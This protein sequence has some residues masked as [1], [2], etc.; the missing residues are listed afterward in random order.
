M[1]S[2]PRRTF[3]G[4]LLTTCLVLLA[5]CPLAA[6]SAPAAEPEAKAP[7]TLDFRLRYR[8]ETS[9][10]SGRFH[11]LTR[12]E[13]WRPEQTAVVVCDMWDLHHCLNATRRGAEVAPRMNQV[14]HALRDRGVTVVHAPSNCMDFYKDHPGR[15]AALNT[16]KAAKL[17]Q[18]IGKW[19]YQIPRE[20]QGVYPI[21]QANGGEDDDP[22]E[23]AE[24]AAKLEKMGRNPRRPWVRQAETLDIEDGDFIS[25][26]GEEIWSIF[27]RRGVENVILVGVHTNMCVLGRPFGLRQMAQNGKNVV[28]MRDMT[29]TMYDP[30]QSPRVSHFTGTDLIVE[31]IEKYV[32]PTVTSDQVLGGET[33][34]F[35][36][37]TRPRLVIVMAEQEYETN[38]T[39]PKFA[40]EH[41]GKHFSIELVFA[42]DEDRNNLPGIEAL[43]NADV[44]LLS[45]RRRVLPK[46]QMAIVR[47]FI[48]SGKPVV[49]VRT[50]SHAF[51]LRNQQ[52]PAGY[53]AWPELDHDILGGNYTNHHGNGPKV[54]VAAAK[55][56]GEHPILA[57]VELD[58]LISAGS[59]YK[60]SPLT[61]TTT[62]LLTGAIDGAAAEPVAWTN[63]PKTGGRV[64]YTSLAHPDDFSQP[65]FN[66]LL[67][68][69][70]YWAAG[71][72]VS[73]TVRYG[74]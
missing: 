3:A 65:A 40:V 72:E 34:R 60:V 68:N 10:Q 58:K 52:P 26:N 50:A 49:G 5:L 51:S 56:A 17:P 74:Y 1:K 63:A 33:F 48:E 57:G 53:E 39:L 13:K 71:V 38:R 47:G 27:E 11:A 30:T 41:L 16:P 43:K 2:L 32:C 4:P 19:C 29:D 45:A 42:N 61:E 18:D 64:F 28:L 59:L 73:D 46:A 22:Q 21:D 70:V 9:P 25:D 6:F 24:W 8:Q 31:H 14:L 7:Q 36:N 62:T 37:D 54:R 23:H 15:L 55:G 12:D 20:E 66:R 35:A 67:R 69:A 44:L